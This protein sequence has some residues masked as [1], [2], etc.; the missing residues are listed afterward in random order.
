LDYAIETASDLVDADK[1]GLHM[2]KEPR[3][4]Q[5]VIALF[6]DLLGAG[7]LKGF[8]FYSTHISEKYDGVAVF[9][10]A[11]SPDVLFDPDACPLG[12]PADKFEQQDGT[13][14]SPKR[15][16]LEFKRTSDDLIRD[17]VRQDKSLPDIRWLVCWEIGDRHTREGY[18]I[19]PITSDDQRNNR[20]YYGVTHLM[21]GAGGHVQV[22]SLKD[23]LGALRAQ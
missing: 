17:L 11:K 5:D 10:L 18:A 1:L 23:V 7:Y 12:V 3:E 8:G 21:T 22:I 4:E 15:S 20:D 9:S 16:F 6:F 19:I 14:R 2:L 13:K